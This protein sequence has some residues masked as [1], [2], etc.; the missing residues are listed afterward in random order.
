VTTVVLDVGG[1]VIPTLFERVRAP[2]FPSGPFQ[3][4]AHPDPEYVQVENG[5]MQ[6]REYWRLLAERHPELDIGHLWRSCSVVREEMTGLLQR[7]AGRVRVTAF[8]NDMAHWFGPDWPARFPILKAFDAIVEASVLGVMK[9]DPAAFRAAAKALDED[10]KRCLF[11]DDLAANLGGAASV[12]MH[13]QLFDVRDAS[14]SMDRIAT[15]LGLPPV[16]AG[17]RVFTTPRRTR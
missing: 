10:P 14:G 13:T 12:G 4:A 1:V 17:R 16:T 8:T 9:P 6:E 11:V 5:T 7:I 2:S 15:V 3:D